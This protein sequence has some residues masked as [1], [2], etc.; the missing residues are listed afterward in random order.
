LRDGAADPAARA[1]DDRDSS[2]EAPHRRET[3]TA[4]TFAAGAAAPP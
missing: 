1:G 2:V 4:T 3:S